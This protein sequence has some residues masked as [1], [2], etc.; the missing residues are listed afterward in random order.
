[1]M[2]RGTKR[3][4]VDESQCFQLPYQGFLQG[5]TV[6]LTCLLAISLVPA[7]ALAT[8]GSANVETGVNDAEAVARFYDSLHLPDGM[9]LNAVVP[10][11]F[12][13]GAGALYTTPRD[14]STVYNASLPDEYDLRD[15]DGKS[16]VTPVK[17]QNPWSTCWAFATDAALESSMLMQG[18][19]ADEV[20]LSERFLSYF[21]RVPASGQTLGLFGASSQVGEGTFSVDADV[22]DAGGNVAE[23]ANF[24][25]SMNGLARESAA[26]YQNDEGV[27]ETREDPLLDGIQASMYSREGTWS[28]D[29]SVMCDSSNRAGNVERAEVI[30]GSYNSYLA[31]T[32]ELALG[33]YD[34]GATS[35]A[36]QAIM[37]GGAIVANYCADVSTPDDEAMSTEN[38][39]MVN[40]RQYMDEPA[41]SN[42]SVAVVGWDDEDSKDNFPTT[43][44]GDGAWIVKN[45]WGCKDG[46]VGGTSGWGVDFQRRP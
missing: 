22:F 7:S 6:V 41:L 20:D 42:H 16:Y 40:W 17:S 45:S 11:G 46:G 25:L 18:V 19:A 35:R 3:R 24:I 33:D 36:K 26:P 38:F 12:V 34:E 5:L 9:Q 2:F 31:S 8:E 30:P 37:D 27:Y 4:P 32:G 39:S 23:A 43:P 29:E 10:A 44:A 13:G 28:L 15:V 21:H 1:M 14:G